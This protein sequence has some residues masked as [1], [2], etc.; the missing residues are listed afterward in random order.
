MSED[1]DLDLQALQR[2]LDDA[3]QTTRPRP[4]FED[5][6]WLRMQARRPIWLRLRDGLAGLID[7]LREAPAVPSAAVAILLIVVVGAGIFAISGLHPGGGTSSLTTGAS[8]DTAGNNFGPN[9]PEYGNLP[10]PSLSGPVA[11]PAQTPTQATEALSNYFGPASLTWAG[12]LDITVTSLPVFLYREPTPATA[13]QF[14]ASLGAAPATQAAPGALGTYAAD[15]L[16]LVVSGT[17][18]QPPRE[19]IFNLTELKSKSA[20]PSSD[21]V[22]LATSYLGA[23]SLVPTWPYTTEVQKSGTTVR[24]RFL[25]SFDV[26]SQGLISLVDGAGDRYGI[27]VDIVAGQPRVVETGP[28]PLSLDS[29]SYPI[30]TADQAVRTALAASASST[31][32]TSYPAVTLTK[33]VLVYKVVWAGDHSFYEPAFLFSGTFNDHGVLKVKRVLVP[34]V[35]PSFLSP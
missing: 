13:D 15:N 4:A 32:G 5:E 9:A 27:E 10:A 31:G 17:V 23:H 1:E 8:R 2:Q 14:A 18:A 29:A 3:F 6:L 21:A 33:A 25:R 12:S 26:P 24:V 22:G 7:G 11:G 20:T 28:L 34:A 30:I 19:P 16:E 35:G